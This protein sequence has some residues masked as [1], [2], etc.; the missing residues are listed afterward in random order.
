MLGRDG[1][2]RIS[3]MLGKLFGKVNSFRQTVFF[4][5]LL[6]S[7][8]ASLDCKGRILTVS[9]VI[10]IRSE[11]LR[12]IDTDIKIDSKVCESRCEEPFAQL[13]IMGF[14]IWSNGKFRDEQA[15]SST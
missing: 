5:L 12:N 14:N 8:L 7:R 3:G 10:Q 15:S 4:G 13:S 6:D 11:T 2:I 9:K 1:Y